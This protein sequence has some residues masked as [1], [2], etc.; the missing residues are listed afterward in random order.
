M[1]RL[2]AGRLVLALLALGLPTAQGAPDARLETAVQEHPDDP[3]LSWALARALAEEGELDAAAARLAAHLERWPQR[4]PEG[5]LLLGRW[6]EEL[7]RDSDALAAFEQAVARDATS[8]A[9]CLHAGLAASRLGRHE[10]AEAHFQRAL[11]VDPSLAAEARLL[12]GL[13]RLELGDEEGARQLLGDVMLHHRESDAARAARLVLEGAPGLRRLPLVSLD[14][15]GGVQFDSNVT[16]ESGVD[17]PGV[18]VD[19]DDVRFLSGVGFSVRPVRGERLGLELGARYDRSYHLELSDYDTQ[20]VL[21]IAGGHYRLGSRVGLRLDGW[22][23]YTTLAD[24]PYLLEGAL[25]P[26]LLV[27]LGG[28]AGTLRFHADGQRLD[29]GEGPLFESLDRDGWSYGGGFDHIVPLVWREGGWASW[30]SVYAR[31]DTE[32]GRDL[33]GFGGAYDHHRVGALAR[34]HV[35]VLWKVDADARAA[36]DAELYDNRNV[37]D[38]LTDG[39]VGR[40]DPRRRRDEL[41]SLAL[42]LTRPVGRFTELEVAW[43][44]TDRISNVDLYAYDRHVVGLTVR[45]FTP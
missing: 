34:L 14:A 9:A 30:G 26:S 4:P 40:P 24:D 16:L 27:G 6:L 25:R 35:P 2:R 11:R 28:P 44:Y 37:V 43:G 31:R 10:A 22:F 42:A 32:A 41:W 12:A 1:R 20:R 18:S 29:Y 21:G 33:L 8:G 38:A 15:Y 7:G 23:G 13:E 3:D 36:F 39:G 5:W 19:Q 45:V 17:F